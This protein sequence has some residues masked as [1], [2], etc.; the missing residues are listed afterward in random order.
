MDRRTV[1]IGPDGYP[2]AG[3]VVADRPAVLTADCD[4]PG[5]VTSA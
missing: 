1:I 4:L 3:P 2:V 5:P